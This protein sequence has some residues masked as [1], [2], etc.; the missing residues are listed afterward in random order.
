MCWKVV[1]LLTICI[2]TLGACGREVRRRGE[3]PIIATHGSRV[4]ALA[5][6]TGT[7]DYDPKTKCLFIEVDL[8]LGPSRRTFPFWPR[9]TRSIIHEGRRG[10]SVPGSGR[11][12][13]GDAIEA[14][15]RDYEPDAFPQLEI[16][17][18]CK[19]YG[20]STINKD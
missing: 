9:G 20:F 2:L 13:D 10:V 6:F 12:L 11:F 14:G 4:S 5:A 15:G 19:K 17:K 8:G 7:I 16:P 18:A 1:S 3:D